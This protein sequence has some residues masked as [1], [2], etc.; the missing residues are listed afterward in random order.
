MLLSIKVGTVNKSL[1]EFSV[2]L[3]APKFVPTALKVAL[4]VGSLLFGINHGAAL[5]RGQMSYERWISASITYLVPYIV[6]IHGQYIS[7]S[8]MRN[9]KLEKK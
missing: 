3:I 8:K 7:F 6:N 4:V 9:L 2:S 1:R 5:L